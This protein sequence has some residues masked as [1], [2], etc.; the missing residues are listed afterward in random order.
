MTNEELEK[1][2]NEDI[3]REIIGKSNFKSML[4]KCKAKSAKRKTV[5]IK[6]STVLTC[7]LVVFICTI[8]I[9]FI[10]HNSQEKSI[11]KNNNMD[12]LE[13]YNMNKLE[14]TI[15]KSS[16][17]D[18]MIDNPNADLIMWYGITITLR[19]D[20]TKHPKFREWESEFTN[21]EHQIDIYDKRPL[22]YHLASFLNR[23]VYE[24]EQMDVLFPNQQIHSFFP[25]NEVIYIDYKAKKNDDERDI[26][27]A[28]KNMEEYLEWFYK[29]EDYNNILKLTNE[30]YIMVININEYWPNNSF[31][32]E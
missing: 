25:G 24:Y 19:C 13:N 9:V 12:K 29:S 1:L 7:L 32:D 22:E 14:K 15:T 17:S 30:D 16:N 18:D 5:L 11:I 20:Y 10:S 4:S 28:N 6:L 31:V 26:E 23:K 21:S 8:T 2:L 3:P 27:Q